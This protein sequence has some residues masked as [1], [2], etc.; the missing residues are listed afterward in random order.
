MVKL[1][2]G[3]HAGG[4]AG[5]SDFLVCFGFFGLAVQFH[6]HWALYIVAE[7]SALVLDKTF[8]GHFSSWR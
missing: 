1:P 5:F 4:A 7:F 6:L 3:V 8:N 2:R